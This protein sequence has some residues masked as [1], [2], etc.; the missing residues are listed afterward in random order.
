MMELD[1]R[2]LQLTDAAPEQKPRRW[3]GGATTGLLA[4]TRIHTEHGWRSVEDIAEGQMVHTR[5]HG[6][7]PVARIERTKVKKHN[8][9]GPR[10][11]VLMPLLVLGN[12]VPFFMLPEQRVLISPRNADD[13]LPGLMPVHRLV[14]YKGISPM[15]MPAASDSYVLQ[16][17][18]EE[19]VK[20]HMGVELLCPSAHGQHGDYAEVEGEE[21]ER[22]I[23]AAGLGHEL[24]RRVRQD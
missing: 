12:S 20:A 13:G 22:L 7:Q 4:K 8:L 6:L 15:H 5:D 9:F 3:T 21:A 14:G 16:F 1:P 24:L 2:T 17:E 18:A 11:V 10:R 19:I 23:S